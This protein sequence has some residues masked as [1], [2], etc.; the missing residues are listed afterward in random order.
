MYTA[1]PH[2]WFCQCIGKP[3]GTKLH[4]VRLAV[5]LVRCLEFFFLKQ[6]SLQVY[7]GDSN[8]V[9]EFWQRWSSSWSCLFHW[10][11]STEFST[12]W[13]HKN[14]QTL[15][16]IDNK[17]CCFLQTDNKSSLLT[18]RLTQ[19]TVYEEVKLVP[20]RTLALMFPSPRY[21]KGFA[22]YK[23]WNTYTEPTKKTLI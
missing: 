12:K 13:F 9:S 1:L 14:K 4:G 10:V 18:S 2:L 21:G 8:E 11:L 6:T 15:Q 3:H 5:F 23:K 20:P 16:G 22:S 17:W 19:L 7:E